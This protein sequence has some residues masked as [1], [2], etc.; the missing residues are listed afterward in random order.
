MFIYL[1]S[2]LRKMLIENFCCGDEGF[3]VSAVL[4]R[5]MLFMKLKEDVKNEIKKWS[6][7]RCLTHVCVCV[8]ANA[9]FCVS[10]CGRERTQEREKLRKIIKLTALDM[11]VYVCVF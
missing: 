2:S 9:C 8:C 6:S 3:L 7:E 5:T 10:V 1:P 11:C 4:F